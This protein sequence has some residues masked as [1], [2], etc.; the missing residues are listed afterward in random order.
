MDGDISEKLVDPIKEIVTR[1]RESKI[2][3]LPLSD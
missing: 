2:D 3:D 1:N